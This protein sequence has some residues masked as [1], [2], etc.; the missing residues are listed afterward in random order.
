MSEVLWMNIPLM[1]L[2]LGLM[3]GIPLWLV[4]RRRDWHDKPE[5]R[6]IPAYLAARRTRRTQAGLIRVPVT[7]R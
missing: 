3:A 5:A 2:C 6:T 1:V 4:V 7:A